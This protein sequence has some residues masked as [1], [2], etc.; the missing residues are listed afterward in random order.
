MGRAWAEQ[1]P[2]TSRASGMA[3][4]GAAV[5]Q[6]G[7]PLR[8]GKGAVFQV[9]ACGPVGR[10]GLVSPGSRPDHAPAAPPSWPISQ[11]A[12]VRPRTGGQA[13]SARDWPTVSAPLVGAWEAG[14]PWKVFSSSPFRLREV[15]WRVWSSAIF[16]SVG[17]AGHAARHG[18]MRRLP[19]P[20]HVKVPTARGQ[21]HE[22]AEPARRADRGVT[23]H[24]HTA[25]F[26]CVSPRTAA[27]PR[28]R[29]ARVANWEGRRSLESIACSSNRP[30]GWL[31]GG[32]ASHHT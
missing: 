5:V 22:P 15:G 26:F 32:H 17:H 1:R 8:K 4:A 7:C 19:A 13:P 10:Q 21:Q 29:Q 6:Q 28:Q 30:R 24:T 18:R 27:R 20:H 16:D 11:S 12:R 2:L 31:A 9:H 14:G 3:Q 23:C 25:T